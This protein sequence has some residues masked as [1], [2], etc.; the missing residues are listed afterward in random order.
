MRFGNVDAAGKL[1]A[2]VHDV[3]AFSSR[4]PGP[5]GPGHC[6]QRCHGAHL[7]PRAISSRQRMSAFGQSC[8]GRSADVPP[9]PGPN[10]DGSLTTCPD[11][12]LRMARSDA[13]PQ[14]G[15]T[16]DTGRARSGARQSHEPQPRRG[17]GV[18]RADH[19]PVRLDPAQLPRGSARG[20][21]DRDRELAALPAVRGPSAAADGTKHDPRALHVR[22]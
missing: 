2:Y 20:V 12:G 3:G 9:R 1:V 5:L 14:Y 15:M 19:R 7:S 17:L 13:T 16:M 8:T 21:R 6:A 18:W 11:A 4:L 22:R 10:R